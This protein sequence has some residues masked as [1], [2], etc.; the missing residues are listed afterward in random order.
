MTQGNEALQ[1][2]QRDR[3]GKHVT[4]TPNNEVGD[5]DWRNRVLDAGNFGERT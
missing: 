5:N 2:V 1:D 3:Q 4:S